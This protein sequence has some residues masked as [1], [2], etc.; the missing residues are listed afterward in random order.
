MIKGLYPFKKVKSFRH[1]EPFFYIN[2][3]Y[4]KINKK[5]RSKIANFIFTNGAGQFTNIVP[6]TYTI[7]QT[8]S[9]ASGY[10]KTSLPASVTVDS[11]GTDV[12]ITIGATGDLYLRALLDGTTA[13]ESIEFTRVYKDFGTT[14]TVYGTVTTAATGIARF[15]NVPFSATDAPYIYYSIAAASD[16][17]LINPVS[18]E[19][20]A[21]IALTDTTTEGSPID[22]SVRRKS[23]TANFTVTDEN[24]IGLPIETGTLTT[25]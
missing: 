13:I 10:D 6:G 20:Y 17:E 19:T 14:A 15:Q 1:K 25:I 5:E 2:I 24:Y 21:R 3:L 7:D 8:N 11:L 4:I 18:G 12:S 16:Y 22:V 23:V 9:V